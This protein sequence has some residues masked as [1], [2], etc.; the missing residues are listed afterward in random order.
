MS[1]SL[2]VYLVTADIERM[3]QFYEE[4]LGIKGARQQGQWLPFTVKGATFALHGGREPGG[5]VDSRGRGGIVPA[6]RRQRVG[7]WERAAREFSDLT[8][9]PS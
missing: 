9:L 7:S 4:G 3:R 6:S 2:T 1:V 8:C 5:P